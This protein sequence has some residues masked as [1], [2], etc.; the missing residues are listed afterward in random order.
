M[1]DAAGQDKQVPESMEVAPPVHGEKDN[2]RRVRYSA[3][4]HPCQAV[5]AERVEER[6]HRDDSNPSLRKVDQR[7]CHLIL[8]NME[9]LEDHP[10][11]GQPPF[12]AKDRPAQRPAQR[13]QAEWRVGARDQQVNGRVVQDVK[14]MPRPRPDQR[15]VERRTDINQHQRRGEDGATDYVP[16][17]PA[18]RHHY[19]VNSARNG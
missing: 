11:D 14:D 8:A 9:A 16:C 2:P 10:E 13:D 3:S 5:P 6:L 1:S 7:R 4:A 12:E 17:R 18:C 19:Q 15:V